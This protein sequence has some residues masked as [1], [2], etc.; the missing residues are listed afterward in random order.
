MNIK[1]YSVFDKKT[2]FYHMPMFAH[3]KGHVLREMMRLLKKQTEFSEYPEDYDLF[4]IGD[5][6]DASGEIKGKMPEFVANLATLVE[7]REEKNGQQGTTNS[8]PDYR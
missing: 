1:V 7:K 6:N 2:L 3:N 5:Y 8:F 4:E